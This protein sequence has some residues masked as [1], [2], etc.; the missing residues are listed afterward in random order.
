MPTQRTFKVSA[1]IAAVAAAALGVSAWLL[2]RQVGELTSATSDAQKAKAAL[3]EEQ[4]RLE[5]TASQLSESARQAQQRASALQESID[6][7][8]RYEQESLQRANRIRELSNGLGAASSVKVAMAEYFMTMGKWPVS[9]QEMGM[10]APDSYKSGALRSIGAEADGKVKLVFG[11]AETQQRLWL[12][13]SANP[14]GAISW[15][16][17][18]PDIA[19][20]TQLVAGCVYSASP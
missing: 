11:S 13:A 12:H 3:A 4:A 16:C 1:I 19:D 9:N 15:R 10:P 18:T 7:S 20:I 17:V 8:R 6:D 5:Q 2:S 14:A